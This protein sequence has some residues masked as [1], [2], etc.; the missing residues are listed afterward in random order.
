M[1]LDEIK[2]ILHE[3][4]VT[5]RILFQTLGFRLGDRRR[6]EQSAKDECRNYP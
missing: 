6:D 5:P 1:I 3:I 2:Y 4:R